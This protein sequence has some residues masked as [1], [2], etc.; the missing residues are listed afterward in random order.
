MFWVATTALLLLLLALGVVAWHAVAGVGVPALPQRL[1]AGM[2]MLGGIVVL[3]GLVSWAV[4]GEDAATR[5]EAARC[6]ECTPGSRADLA[7]A[8]SDLLLGR[9]GAPGIGTGPG[10]QLALIR[11]ELGQLQRQSAIDDPLLAA[12]MELLCARVDRVLHALRERYW[13]ADTG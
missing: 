2:L 5:R 8:E 9:L 13:V 4:H 6:R 1:H 11:A 3:L 7:L 10:A 12:R